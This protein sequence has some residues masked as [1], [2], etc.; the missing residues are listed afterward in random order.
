[1][2]EFLE[3]IVVYRNRSGVGHGTVQSNAQLLE[4]SQRLLYALEKIYISLDTLK[5][6]ELVG[7]FKEETDEEIFPFQG[8]ADISEG[9][10]SRSLALRDETGKTQLPLEPWV[11]F[12]M[13]GAWPRGTSFSSTAKQRK[14]S[15][16]T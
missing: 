2:G 15:T 10:S 1:M 13:M 3:R 4:A 12:R 14:G 7:F 6:L 5:N 11:R 16:I 8:F 9:H